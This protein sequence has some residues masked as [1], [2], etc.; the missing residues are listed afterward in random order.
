M[1]LGFMGFGKY[2][3]YS[4]QKESGATNI[5]PPLYITYNNNGGQRE[6][7]SGPDDTSV[8]WAT[9]FF[10]FFS[11]VYPTNISFSI[12]GSIIVISD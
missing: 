5:P 8:V 1:T 2:Q 9:G 3:N 10:F 6:H 12:S 11:F 4:K 7:K